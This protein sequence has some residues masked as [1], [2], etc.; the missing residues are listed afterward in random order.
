MKARPRKL[1]RA[2]FSESMIERRQTGCVAM[3]LN[4]GAL[5]V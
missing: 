3:A 2:F 5:S 1:G 4:A